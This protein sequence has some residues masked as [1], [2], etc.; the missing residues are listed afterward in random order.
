MKEKEKTIQR[1]IARKLKVFLREI[2]MEVDTLKQETNAHQLFEYQKNTFDGVTKE[3]P[4]DIE[5]QLPIE[6]IQPIILGD[7]L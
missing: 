5:I 3:H 4:M 1:K 6:M 7:A 2:T